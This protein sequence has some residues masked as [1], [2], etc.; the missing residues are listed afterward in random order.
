MSN[1]VTRWIRAGIELC[2]ACWRPAS[3]GTL[4]PRANKR[5]RRRYWMIGKVLRIGVDI[6]RG[7]GSSL[8]VDGD[9]KSKSVTGEEGC[10][11]KQIST[12]D[13]DPTSPTKTVSDGGHK[14]EGKVRT[15]KHKHKR[16]K[17]SGRRKMRD[18]LLC[19]L[20]AR[21]NA[22][23]LRSRY[24]DLQTVKNSDELGISEL[25]KGPF[26]EKFFKTK[27]RGK[28]RHSLTVT[29]ID[30]EV[31]EKVQKR[32]GHCKSAWAECEG[33]MRDVASVEETYDA[34]HVKGR[35]GKSHVSKASIG[36]NHGRNVDDHTQV[37]D[38]NQ[39]SGKEYEG[40]STPGEVSGQ[41]EPNGGRDLVIRGKFESEKHKEGTTDL[42]DA[43]VVYESSSEESVIS[44]AEGDAQG[45]FSDPAYPPIINRLTARCVGL[46][47][48]DNDDDDDYYDGD[49]DYDDDDDDDEEI[50]T[51]SYAASSKLTAHGP[52][53]T[54][55]ECSHNDGQR[56]RS[57]IQDPERAE[58]D[59][60]TNGSFEI[61]V[62][63]RVDGHKTTDSNKSKDKTQDINE[64]GSSGKTPRSNKQEAGDWQDL[65]GHA[66]WQS[67]P[68]T[69]PTACPEVLDSSVVGEQSVV[70]LTKAPLVGEQAKDFQ[71][72]MAKPPQHPTRLKKRKIPGEIQGQEN[73]VEDQVNIS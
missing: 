56:D 13:H 44:A 60:F 11:N 16:R 5:K 3:A 68:Q 49:V 67:Q 36:P 25:K 14:R 61:S 48:D 34:V 33:H 50:T 45:V 73:T 37:Y 71:G 15:R 63:I 2:A 52:D 24:L 10:Q 17:I 35:P 38:I 28:R 59:D 29:Q 43:A 26:S 20:Q 21:K 62:S 23:D 51:D 64:E 31:Y 54:S 40:M 65:P 55:D 19:K 30:K 42:V 12:K 27:S 39:D 6:C 69:S 32:F 72:T 7:H 53:K 47:I 41:N 9:Q 70:K 46:D 57:S 58:E 66:S 18:R 22:I 8:R 1:K 4:L